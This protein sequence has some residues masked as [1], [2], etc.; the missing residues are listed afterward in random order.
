MRALSFS[1]CAVLFAFGLN[2]QQKNDT[3]SAEPNNSVERLIFLDSIIESKI[4]LAPKEAVRFAYEASTIAKDMAQSEIV[5]KTYRVIGDNYMILGIY[6]RALTMYAK[7]IKICQDNA[8]N[9]IQAETHISVGELY[10][11]QMILPLAME[12]FNRARDYFK[13]EN[14][15]SG[16][17]RALQGIGRVYLL[18]NEY[19]EALA[20]FRHS[21]SK[22][23]KAGDLRQVAI[24]F[25]LMGE[26]HDL[27][28]GIDEAFRFYRESKDLLDGTDNKDILGSTFWKI[29]ELHVK[30]EDFQSALENYIKSL[31]IF[32]S[33][34][35]K[36]R[37]SQT[38]LH[39][40]KLYL[41]EKD[42]RQV[43][44]L[45]AQ[46]LRISS[47]NGFLIQLKEAYKLMADAS[48][49]LED[50]ETALMNY[51]KYS[52][53]KDSIFNANLANVITDIEVRNEA[54]K[55]NRAIDELE[56]SQLEQRVELAE[57]NAQRNILMIVLAFAIALAAVLFYL[58]TTKNRANKLILESKR[59]AEDATKAKA[60]FLST[61]S[62]E[63]RTPMNAIIGMTHL[64]TKENLKEE[65]KDKVEII[66]FSANNLLNL[67]ND[68]LDF[69]KIESG[70]IEFEELVFKPAELIN[71]L[72]K[73]FEER[74]IENG[75]D[76]NFRI[77]SN[78]PET[79][80]G[81][82]SRLSQILINL[83]GN[84]IKFTDKGGVEIKVEEKQ[85]QG[86]VSTLIFKVID[87]GIGISEEKQAKI[88]ESF[89]QADSQI[90]R[91]YG[92][93]GL[94]LAITKSLVELQDG[95]I[96]LISQP[97]LGSEFIVELKFELALEPQ[98]SND[99]EKEVDENKLRGKR[100]LIVEDDIINQKVA[101]NILSKWDVEIEVAENGKVALEKLQ[102]E[103]FDII[104]MDLH[105]PEM[106]GYEATQAI[107]ALNGDSGKDK[108][109]IIALTADAFTDVRD[110]IMEFKMN[111]YVSKPFVPD[112]LKKKISKNLN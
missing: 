34:N 101:Q 46:S 89:S 45:A 64:L 3:L 91:K 4:Y 9:A 76:F 17:A 37:E 44:N 62:H 105:M 47:K 51:Q 92:G 19:E 31:W 35:D 82:P 20:S 70:K 84:A 87:T 100:V 86:I 78:V 108:T 49:E 58:Y 22:A 111:D 56:K 110:R 103:D 32:K 39:L 85:R 53:M 33:L 36:Y 16:E 88:F 14:S 29:G 69:S 23:E 71:N 60:N 68:I 38:Y 27:N 66:N 59:Q 48:M 52:M 55:K 81:D 107:R 41:K 61:M 24:S 25:G 98:T 12:N 95:K 90:S 73:T 96:R 79:V 83:I 102:K 26:A 104:L 10:T 1:L 99:D 18:L 106:N 43:E 2:A 42:Y 80:K 21:L 72:Y 65:Q 54:D 28:G 75:L 77:G 11:E 97:G 8:F 63:I 57:K 112:E 13:L 6:D 93:T 40:A 5:A 50:Y 15:L 7:G 109:P 94:G 67:I 30:N 74:T